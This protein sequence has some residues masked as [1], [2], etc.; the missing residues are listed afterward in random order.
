MKMRG[1]APSAGEH[2]LKITN[3]GVRVYPRHGNAEQPV[4]LARS[5]AE[6]RRSTGITGLDEM[7]GGG[8]PTGY[9]ILVAG[10]SGSG[11]TILATEFIRD[12]IARGE[13]GVIAVFDK[14]PDDYLLTTPNGR[15][16][17]PQVGRGSLGLLHLRPLD[18][19]IE[20]TLEEIGNAVAAVG[21]KRVVIDSLSGLELAVSAQFR[22]DFRESLYRVI[23]GLV[24]L[25]VTVMLTAEIAESYTELQFGPHGVSFLADGIIVQRYVELD[26]TL[27]RL[28]FVAKMRG[29][30]HSSDLK[31]YDIDATGIT[32]REK[33]TGYTGLLAG[34][35]RRAHADD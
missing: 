32:V 13:P 8:I 30:P 20:E 2:T 11:K 21:A 15:D 10:P 17:A 16:L 22:E 25:G 7:L 33:L 9:S 26:G 23:G 12:G 3:A 19:S 29:F 27:R 28:M 24:R 31:L 35:A 5:Q 18:L 34:K 4:A 14:R 6:P 1:Q